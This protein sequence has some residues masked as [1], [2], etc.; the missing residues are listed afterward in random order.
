ML[1]SDWHR[2]YISSIPD[3]SRLGGIGKSS[4]DVRPTLEGGGSGLGKLLLFSILGVIVT[5]AILWGESYVVNTLP[6]GP[7]KDQVIR[8]LII[9]LEAL[10]VVFVIGAIVS[11]AIWIHNS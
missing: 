6:S 3:V 7:A 8:N 11:I 2:K 1:K 4:I 9:P 5:S 10:V